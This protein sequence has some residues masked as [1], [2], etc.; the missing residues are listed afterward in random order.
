MEKVDDINKM[1]LKLLSEQIVPTFK[2]LKRENNNKYDIWG[3]KN[4]IRV[5]YDHHFYYIDIIEENAE[6]YWKLTPYK[7]SF[8]TTIASDNSFERVLFAITEAQAR[9]ERK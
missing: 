5:K 9:K 7:D 8:Y 3:Y 4:L 2:K 1:K 6:F